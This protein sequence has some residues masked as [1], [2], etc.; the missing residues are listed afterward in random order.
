MPLTKYIVRLTDEERT[1]LEELIHTGTQRA[2]ATLIH[3]RILLK[4]DAGP[5]GPGW[6]DDRIA[7]A[8]DCGT[9]TV[10]RVR[11]AFVEEGLMA[12]LYRKKPTGRLYRKLDGEQEAQLIALAC[13]TPPVGRIHWTMR[14]L[15]DRLVELQVVDAIS[16][17]C[18]RTTLKKTNSSP[19]YRSSGSFRPKPMLILSARWRTFSRSIPGPTIRPDRSSALM[20]STNNG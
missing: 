2:A 18:V 15:A 19:G 9:S 17:E 10:Y 20:N 1:S 3:A 8:V 12:A 11:Q 4:A 13:S 16:P 14:L 7:E 6:E 5:G